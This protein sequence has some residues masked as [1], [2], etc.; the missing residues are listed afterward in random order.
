MRL[1]SIYTVFAFL[2]LCQ[3]GFS[4]ENLFQST[5]FRIGTI[6][7]TY[8]KGNKLEFCKIYFDNYGERY[9][10]DIKL[11]KDDSDP[12]KSIIKKDGFVYYIMHKK[13]QVLKV[14]DKKGLI[15]YDTTN[16]QRT[17]DTLFV[18]YPSV[19][20]QDEEEGIE[21]IYYDKLL[22]YLSDKKKG[23]KYE[24]TKVYENE[25]FPGYV[26]FLPKNF[27]ITEMNY[28]FSTDFE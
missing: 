17:K 8:K 28:N 6:D 10:V 23:I 2:L 14:P 27:Q 5:P 20:Y 21:L 7:A 24:V 18:N 3:N 12:Y 16:F 19:L 1:L 11:S 4:Q 22:L 13:K 25:E 26:F 9:S 15:N